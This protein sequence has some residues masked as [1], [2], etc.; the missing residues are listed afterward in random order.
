MAAI[1]IT[2][3]DKSLS[4]AG[5]PSIQG[6]MVIVADR[7]RVDTPVTVDKNS[8][9]SL[10]G[11][12]N[13][14]KSTTHYSAM[15]FLEKA[16]DMLV[17]RAIHTA[18]EGSLETENNRTARYAAALVRHKVA[19]IPDSIPDGTY[20]PDRI[21]EPY[22]LTDGFG[23]TQK[24]VDSFTFPVYERDRAY[25]KVKNKVAVPTE[26]SNL[27][28]LNNL[29]GIEV[30]NKLS[31]GEDPNDD[32][33]VFTVTAL[34][35]ENVKVPSVTLEC[36]KSGT[37]LNFT[38][39][40]K[41]R[42]VSL[43]IE[44]LS[45]ATTVGVQANAA[46]TT[47]TLSNVTGI[48]PGM[49]LLFGDSETEKHVV[50]SVNT[51]NKQVTLRN[52]LNAQVASGAQ[53]RKETRSYEDITG[54]PYILR[55]AK[56][57]D[58]IYVSDSD[59]L[60]N[61]G[62]YTAMDGLTNDETEFIV[63]KKSIYNEEQYRAV[64]DKET[65]TALDTVIQL[66]TAS[67]FEERD[68][69]LLLA[70]NQ[71]SWGNNVT[72]EILPSPDYPDMC[73]IIKVLNN[74][75]DTGEKYE[76]AFKEFVDGLGKQLYIEDVINNNSNY[77][78]VKHNPDAVD[79]EGNPALPLINNYTIWREN[80]ED[81]FN[82]SAIKI[83]E[84]LV[85]GDTDIIVTDYSTLEPGTRIKFGNFEQ[86]YKVTGK[87]ANQV[88]NLGSTKT[89]YHITID[90]GIEVDRIE[91]GAF[92]RI[93]AK[94]QF[95][96]VQKIDNQILPSTALNSNYVISGV[97]GKVLDA[98]AN[99]LIG[100]HNGSL[101]DVGDLIQTLNKCF[102]NRDEIN[103]NILLDGGIYNPIYQQRLD[104]LAQN[105]E[106]CFAFLSGDP[107]A[108]AHTDPVQAVIKA[109]NSQNI[110]SSYSA[111]FPDWVTI[112]D[113]YNK[114]NVNVQT[115]GLAAAL[116]SVVSEGGVWG[117]VAAGWSNGKLFNVIKPVVAWTEAQREKL[118]NAQLNPIKKY[119]SRGMCI[120]GNKTNLGA[121][122]YMQM[123]NVR[124][125][126]LQLNIQL[127]EYLEDIHWTFNDEETRR[128]VTS[129]IQDTFWS[130]Y[131][132][133]LNNLQVMDRTTATD[134]DAGNMKIYVAIQPKGVVENIYV[135]M[136]VF[137]NSRSIEVG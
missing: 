112:Y 3:E 101:P 71:G 49:T 104:T 124:F 68:V 2:E 102:S 130:S 122:S 119:K 84:D 76:V 63:K 114:V 37:L 51:G 137:S 109:R 75:V 105:R 96:K 32:S 128:M 132:S 97:A 20:V 90:R 39:K 45:P 91:K 18:A 4:V 55:D 99:L 50:Q 66:M 115:D 24:D 107:T 118:L 108:L 82:T 44:P 92:L 127:R 38:A 17:A 80:P 14:K 30:G 88:N 98:G 121:R 22:K 136:G 1:Y 33:P 111:T 78:R 100:G 74:G 54:N 110:N 81:I 83:D 94:Q 21:V 86:E 34:E 125:L 41:L 79:A 47:I 61:D 31:F 131:G 64:L 11:T 123:R 16:S 70:D 59:Q 5:T 133:V 93:F 29:N 73:R 7:G 43:T 9:I 113:E 117:N 77:I 62:R 135:T 26:N 120:W 87:S 25:K 129:T 103:I 10:Y 56:G 65:T 8:L 35:T 134:V 42:R 12:P 23:L 89:E 19:P 72:V 15:F 27:L 40:A 52:G 106:D 126:L 6:A 13:P 116:Q 69:L 58:V 67:E 53:V 48:K 46:D 85:Y 36:P 95:K 57:S 60:V 28:I